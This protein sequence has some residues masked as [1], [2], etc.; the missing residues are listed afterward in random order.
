MKYTCDSFYHMS[1]QNIKK[2][3]ARGYFVRLI[4]PQP[5]L[6]RIVCIKLFEFHSNGI[7]R[8]ELRGNI[9]QRLFGIS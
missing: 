1:K 3:H 4:G 2:L 6:P 8:F 9:T 7:I 5:S